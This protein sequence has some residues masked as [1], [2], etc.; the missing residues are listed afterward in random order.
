VANEV[1]FNQ[2]GPD[3]ASIFDGLQTQQQVKNFIQIHGKE[4]SDTRIRY[5]GVGWNDTELTQ[6][7]NGE[8]PGAI[9]E[10]MMY[11]SFEPYYDQYV[12]NGSPT[13]VHTQNKDFTFRNYMI[14]M[15]A[16]F[17]RA[18][19]YGQWLVAEKTLMKDMDQ[20]NDY[21]AAIGEGPLA[22]TRAEAQASGDIWRWDRYQRS[23]GK[24]SR[25]TGPHPFTAAEGEMLI[26]NV[27]LYNQWDEAF[28]K[29]GL[30]TPSM[31]EVSAAAEEFGTPENM[32]FTLIAKG[33]TEE[34]SDAALAFFDSAGFG[35]EDITNAYKQGSGEFFKQIQAFADM[36]PIYKRR[37]GID[38]ISGGNIQDINTLDA[39]IK[40]YT[41]STNL[42]AWYNAE[43]FA[44]S[45]GQQEL[46]SL[47]PFGLDT[48][49]TESTLAEGAFSGQQASLQTKINQA[50]ERKKAAFTQS[51]TAGGGGG[52]S[53]QGDDFNLS[54]LFG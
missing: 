12:A 9:D 29:R 22:A 15:Q 21:L 53:G 50:R 3:M 36:N 52:Q 47:Q 26:G 18:S 51:A 45:V 6:M 35:E 20:V 54:Q 40:D 10:Y 42:A 23:K 44:A 13:N 33:Q 25:Q 31:T 32:K 49:L 41:D 17:K 28:V 16:E 4:I 48:N 38:T 2:P 34:L 27:N 5:V 39:L 11:A 30:P 1:N 7:A 19:A 46:T 43:D 37:H 14:T 24:L 8:F